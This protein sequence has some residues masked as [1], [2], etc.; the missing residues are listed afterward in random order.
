[1]EQVERTGTGDESEHGDGPRDAV[2]L[3]DDGHRSP[4]KKTGV[5]WEALDILALVALVLGF[6]YC[7]IYKIDPNTSGLL[8]LLV[9]FIIRGRVTLN[10]RNRQ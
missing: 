9:G 1:M 2:H 6:A 7:L 3:R 5:Q 4:R 8:M 10:G